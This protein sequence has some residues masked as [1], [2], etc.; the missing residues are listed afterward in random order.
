MKPRTRY[1]IKQGHIYR[2]RVLS[3]KKDGRDFWAETT[4]IPLIHEKTNEI[5]EY[6]CTQYAKY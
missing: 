4:I 6:E 3:R 1:L 5:L 2:E